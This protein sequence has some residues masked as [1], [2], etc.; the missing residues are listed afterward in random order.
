MLVGLTSGS[1][2]NIDL[3]MALRKRL[4]L[5]G[6][7]LRGRSLE[8]KAEAVGEFASEVVPLLADGRVKANVDRVFDI[9]EVR[10]AHEYLESNES[11]GKVV[12]KIAD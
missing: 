12:L 2:A 6:T 4:T 8:E 9:A 1:K 11:F 5:I 3:G 10:N 7:V